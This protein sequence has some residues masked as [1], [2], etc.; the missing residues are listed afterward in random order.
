MIFHSYV[1]IL[2]FH[3]YKLLRLYNHKINI[4]I[5]IQFHDDVPKFFVLS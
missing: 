5:N 1:M 3:F 4:K 2:L